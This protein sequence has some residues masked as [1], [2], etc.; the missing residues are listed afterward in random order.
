MS[1]KTYGL[2]YERKEKKYLES[3]GYIAMRCRGSFGMYD[4]VSY[5][6]EFG[7]K[8]T[9]VK[10]TRDKKKS[11]QSEIKKLKSIVVPQG[12]RVTLAIFR[13]GVKEVVV[14]K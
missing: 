1:N 4:I 6:P 14:I 5:H 12:T 7:W 3:E 13:R 9:S 2:N 11:F 8:L 10:A